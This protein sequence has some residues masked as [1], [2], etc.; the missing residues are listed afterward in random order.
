V[1]IVALVFLRGI[2]L[3]QIGAVLEPLHAKQHRIAL[4]PPGQLNPGGCRLAPEAEAEEGPLGQAGHP[5]SL[6]L[7]VRRECT[8]GLSKRRVLGLATAYNWLPRPLQRPKHRPCASSELGE[9]RQRRKLCLSG[10]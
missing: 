4:N 6:L 8:Q 10:F 7:P 3:A 1:A 2:D 9:G 5:T